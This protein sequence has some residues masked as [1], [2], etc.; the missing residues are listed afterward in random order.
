MRIRY[1]LIGEGNV[2]SEPFTTGEIYLP[3]GEAVEHLIFALR[4]RSKFRIE[5]DGRV[6]KVVFGQTN[7]PRLYEEIEFSSDDPDATFRMVRLM[8]IFT[9]NVLGM[10]S[11]VLNMEQ[12]FRLTCTQIGR[13]LGVVPDQ[14]G[15]FVP[16]EW[17]V[18]KPF[19]VR[20]LNLELDLPS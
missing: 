15:T 12:M 3:W 13:R 17:D 8:Q 10:S 11:N 1:V 2:G 19:L 7:A 6:A 9:L 18:L 4:E 5:I 14:S 20:L 16:A